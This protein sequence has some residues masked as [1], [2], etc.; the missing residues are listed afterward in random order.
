[1]N[2]I[3][4]RAAIVGI[5]TSV[6]S[7]N[8]EKTELR[9]IC[10]CVRDALD[11]AGLLPTDIDGMVK[12]AD[13]PTDEI[14]V[15][16][17]MGIGNLTYFGECRWDGASC[18]MVLRAVIGI[19][20]G[21]AN[22]VVVYR[23]VNTSSKVRQRANSRGVNQPPTGE[24]VRLALHAPFGLMSEAGEIGL[25][26]RRYMHNY[27]IDRDHFGW[28]TEVCRDHGARNPNSMYYN[29]P[30]GM[31]EYLQSDDIVH[32]LRTLDCYEECDGGVALI[33]TSTENAKHLK[34]KPVNILGATQSQY[35]GVDE[36]SACYR[37]RMS[38]LP[39]IH[40]VGEKLYSMAGVS[41][42]DIQVVQLDDA[43]APLVPIQ[44][45]ELGFCRP[46]EAPG[47]CEGGNRIRY[48]GQLPLNTSGGSLGEGYM[49][50][51]NHIIE[52]VRQVRGSSTS[53]VSDVELALVVSG[54]VGPA[55]GLVLGEGHF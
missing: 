3:S 50:N 2:N 8:S 5:G 15:T 22:Y 17:A 32:P 12:H 26:V 43:Y 11:D 13:D 28:I 29:R 7:K 9:L 10:E 51:M 47:F 49:Y 48:G 46:G 1:M 39:E 55:S 27:G 44:L 31:E 42:K 20:T 18:G 23:A 16:S 37:D 38:S 14:A 45:E 25:I 21:M 4:N 40:H 54:A 35:Q 52:A 41:P 34:Q 19:V 30:V 6:F 36:K 33:I 53:Q 24:L